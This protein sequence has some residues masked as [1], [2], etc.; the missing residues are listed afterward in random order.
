MFVEEHD[1]A[2]Q[3]IS[4]FVMAHLLGDAHH[5]DPPLAQGANGKLG[6]DR[7][8]EVSAEGMNDD[9]LEA[10]LTVFRLL[11]HFIEI[12]AGALK[13]TAGVLVLSDHLPTPL[14]TKRLELL[15]LVRN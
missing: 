10:S 3:E 14:L 9:P 11:Q 1:E 4:R 5:F 2:T 15:S 7:I 12:R 13:P 8:P 6:L